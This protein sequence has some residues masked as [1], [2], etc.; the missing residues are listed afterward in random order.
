MGAESYRSYFY[1]VHVMLRI[2]RCSWLDP[3]L[4]PARERACTR[5]ETRAQPLGYMCC[6]EGRATQ[7]DRA[8]TPGPLG[9]VLLGLLLSTLLQ[10]AACQCGR[11]RPR[12]HPQTY[13]FNRW[14]FSGRNTGCTHFQSGIKH[15]LRDSMWLIVHMLASEGGSG[16]VQ[17]GCW[18]LNLTCS[19][20]LLWALESLHSIS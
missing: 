16:C 20:M 4:A 13:F 5:M 6:S 8:I 14:S 7:S 2:T 19:P 15:C 10:N 18:V 12:A 1:I 11:R 17:L 9:L 3:C